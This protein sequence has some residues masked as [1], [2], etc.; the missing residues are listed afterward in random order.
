MTAPRLDR[1]LTAYRIGDPNGAHPIFDATGSKLYPGRWN[2]AVSPMIYASQHYSTAMQEKLVRGSGSLPPNQ[3]FIEITI[4]NGIDY[5][6]VDPARLPGWDDPT[7]GVS[8]AFGASWQA[9]KRS[10]L[11]IVPSVVARMEHNFLL[12][13]EHPGFPQVTHG[14]HRPVWWDGRLFVAGAAMAA[15]V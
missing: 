12:N 13:P 4:P 15:P 10:L 7:C 11:L 6:M 14:L 2:T 3:H 5:E 9:S 1:V 8:K